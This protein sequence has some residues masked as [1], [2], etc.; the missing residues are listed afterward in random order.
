MN[1]GLR[2]GETQSKGKKC[3]WSPSGYVQKEWGKKYFLN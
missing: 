2:I 1:R 3:N